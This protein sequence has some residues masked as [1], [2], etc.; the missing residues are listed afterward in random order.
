MLLVSEIFLAVSKKY[1]KDYVRNQI[2]KCGCQIIS[3]KKLPI[4]MG[5][6]SLAV[7]LSDTLRPD[8]IPG[9]QTKTRRAIRLVPS[10]LW[11]KPELIN[12]GEYSYF[13]IS[14]SQ[15][16]QCPEHILFENDNDT[17]LGNSLSDRNFPYMLDPF[18]NALSALRGPKYRVYAWGKNKFK[19]DQNHKHR[20][21]ASEI[22]QELDEVELV[23]E[24]TGT[25]LYSLEDAGILNGKSIVLQGSF[26]NLE[27]NQ[28]DGD[29]TD[30]DF[31]TS[32]ATD[33]NKGYEIVESGLFIDANL[34][35][36]HFLSESVRP[37]IL[38]VE[39]AIP[40]LNLLVRSGLPM[41]FYEVLTRICPDARIIQLQ[42]D[43]KIKVTH[44]LCGISFLN[45]SAN[46]EIF[47]ADDNV[48]EFAQSDE[49]YAWTYINQR[50]QPIPVK[51]ECVYISRKRIDSR[52]IWNA[53]TIELKLQVFGFDVISSNN[54]NEYLPRIAKSSLLCS[55]DGAGMANMIFLAKGARVIELSP[56]RPGW[57]NMALAL[58]LEYSNLPL[59]AIGKGKLAT[60]LDMYYFRKKHFRQL[61]NMATSI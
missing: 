7:E 32:E 48:I 3:T 55:S 19:P 30:G 28:I 46:D 29:R 16:F 6:F 27:L 61:T 60:I 22:I 37:L 54:E 56:G 20:I 25:K 21:S 45:L 52:G 31:K 43:S 47:Y 26:I 38:A 15:S 13:V 44:L 49:M 1:K 18:N 17:W 39:R 11:R 40:I 10:I 51:R 33:L 35:L 9:E 53:K 5:V 4:F 59:A 50:L 12:P 24:W 8:F 2:M 42:W 34:N 41:Q 58:G 57:K 36:Y 23:A 14:L